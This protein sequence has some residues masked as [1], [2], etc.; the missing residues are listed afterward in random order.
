MT[1]KDL[2]RIVLSDSES[3]TSA[4]SAAMQNLL[5]KLKDRPFYIWSNDKHK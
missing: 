4:D 2:Q 5:R 3:N 1:I